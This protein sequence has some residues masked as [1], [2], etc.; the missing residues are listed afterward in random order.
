MFSAI[1]AVGAVFAAYFAGRTVREARE[2][3]YYARAVVREERDERL[4][5]RVETMI[6]I[7]NDIRVMNREGRQEESRVKQV[8]LLALIPPEGALAPLPDTRALATR[9]F[10][11]HADDPDDYG[12]TDEEIANAA[13]AELAGWASVLSA[14]SYD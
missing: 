11:S 13:L 12:K 5:R 14:F 9:Q 2:A 3:S 7:A 6:A 4:A 10:R 1:A 8:R